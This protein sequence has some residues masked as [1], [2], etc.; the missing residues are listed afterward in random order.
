MSFL[1][2]YFGLPA[3]AY[4]NRAPATPAPAPAPPANS[5]INP[6]CGKPQ[7][8]SNET[9]P[10]RALPASWYISEEMYQ[11]ERRAIFSKRWL[12]TTH[13][14]RVPN[15]GDWQRYQ[16]ANFHY[17]VCR[18]NNGKINAFHITPELEEFNINEH[19]ILPIHVHIDKKN[20]IWV[21]LDAGE[22]PEIAW[23]EELGGADEQPR[24]D[25]YDWESYEYDHTWEM[26]GAYNWKLLGDNYN[27]CYHCRVSHPD[28]NDLADINTYVVDPVKSYLMHFGSPTPEMIEK[29][30]L[31]APTY[32]FPNSSI[33]VS[34]HFFMMQRFIPTGTNS[35]IMRYEVYRNKNSPREDFE[36]VDAMYK[37]VMSEDKELAIG[38][39]NNILRGVFINGELHPGMEK[40]ALWFQSSAR[41]MVKEHHEREVEAGR[42]IWPAQQS[43]ARIIAAT[44]GNAAQLEPVEAVI[45]Q[46]IAV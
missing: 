2:N 7:N 21:N 31:I 36:Q 46:A 26:E 39:Q 1:R 3:S 14:K 10:V 34:K 45:R 5:R 22:T 23:S 32:F 18:D 19:G 29:G 42:E 12:L 33:N 44:S 11:L 15:N 24:L 37:R 40:G 27:E 38:A 13:N 16:I 35:S 6:L 8:A 41:D 30:L 17:V 28:L 9:A 43:M 20:F 4:V 25:M